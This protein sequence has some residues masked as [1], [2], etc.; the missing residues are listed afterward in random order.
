MGK[1][2]NVEIQNN[3][4]RERYELVSLGDDVQQVHKKVLY[5]NINRNET[6][7]NIKYQDQ[8]LFDNDV[9]FYYEY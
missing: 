2:Y 9:G 8:V 3:T 6:I 7:L 4:T 5:S 1:L